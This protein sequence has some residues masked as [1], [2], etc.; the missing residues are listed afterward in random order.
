ML[1]TTILILILT[2]LVAVSI[3]HRLRLSP[4]VGYMLVGIF[5][6]PHGLSVVETSDT[7]HAMAQFGVVFLMFTIGLEFSL[8]RL[9]ADKSMVL[10]TGGLQLVITTIVFAL[11]AWML[12]MQLIA[13]FA[14]STAL[15]MSSTAI[16]IRMLIEQAELNTRFGRTAVGILI[17]QDLATIVLLLILPVLKL[18]SL[19]EFASDLITVLAKGVAVFIV[20]VVIGQKAIRP[21]FRHIAATHTPELFMLAVLLVSLG[22]AEFAQLAGLSPVLGGFMAGMVLGE[23]EFRHQVA[24]DI[25][26]FQDV[27]LGLF[28]IT[29]GMVMDTNILYYVWPAAI[30]VTVAFMLAKLIIVAGIGKVSGLQLNIAMRTGLVLAQGGEFSLV[31]LFL[32]LEMGLIKGATGQVLLSAVLLSM[33]LAP[34]IIRFNAPLVEWLS[35]SSLLNWYDH[36]DQTII[37]TAAKLESHV[38]LCGYGRVGQNVGRFL[39]EEGFE[40]VALDLDPYRVR[41]ASEAGEPVSYG[42]ATRHHVLQAAG[43]EKARAIVITFNDNHAAIKILGFAHGLRPDITV[44]VRTVDDINLE[45]LL[46]EGATEV[47]PDTLE[48][49]L[50]LAAHLLMLLGVPVARVAK[51]SA[52]IRSDR[53]RLLRGFFH[54]GGSLRRRHDRLQVLTLPKDAY[55]V[56]RTLAELNLLQD[57]I[58]VTAVRRHTRSGSAT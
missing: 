18:N 20:L 11:C 23:T 4:I 24:A 32:A 45:E 46:N 8:P 57:H 14:V 36:Q 30:I 58:V 2:S 39:T 51:R 50:T 29:I 26:P 49:S 3:I 42:D 56:G 44:L 55:A 28:F 31:I 48:A 37:D 7:I 13:A 35:N 9:I 17:F 10:M 15:A 1:I 41:T 53:Y 40:Y 25:R 6:G 16:V 52:E 5:V 47:I 21:F 38:I 22:A 33:I 27:L 34:L 43:L 12:G 19:I 54:E